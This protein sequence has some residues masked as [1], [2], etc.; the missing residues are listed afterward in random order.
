MVDVRGLENNPGELL[1]QVVLL[2]RCS[3]GGEAGYL[4]GF[5]GTE[6]LRDQVVGFVPG[7]LDK[8]AVLLDQRFREAVG[9]V[10]KF[11]GIAS[12]GAEFATVDGRAL[13]VRHVKDPAVPDD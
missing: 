10:D 3:G 6:L 9:A 8:P 13:P 2:V 4:V 11:V 12:F 1:H 7:R 5:V